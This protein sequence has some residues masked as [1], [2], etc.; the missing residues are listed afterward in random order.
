V[1]NWRGVERADGTIRD[2]EPNTL[3]S[4]DVPDKHYDSLFPE[5]VRPSAPPA[6]EARPGA[7]LN[8][9]QYT[10]TIDEAVEMYQLAEVARPKRRIQKYCARGDLDCLKVENTFGGEQYMITRS[11]IDVHIAFLQQAE[12]AALGRAGARL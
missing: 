11:S 10:I 8:P 7:P 4:P 3:T 2:M 12:A 9:S 6:A 5:D 1:D